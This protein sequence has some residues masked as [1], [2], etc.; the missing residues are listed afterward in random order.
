[1]FLGIRYLADKKEAKERFLDV[2]AFVER[3][4][5]LG[6]E[7]VYVL[8]TSAGGTSAIRFTQMYPE[9]T[10]GLILYCSAYPRLEA[11]EKELTM[12]GPPFFVCN[13]LMM[14]LISPLFE[15]LMGMEQSTIKEIMSM[16]DK[17]HGIVFDGKIT[18]TVMYNHYQEYDIIHLE[19]P[20]LIIYAKDDKLS[21]VCI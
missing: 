21:G 9:R 1:M 2:M 8:A 18:N 5:S 15:P 4:D 10:K 3:L 12:A 19:M 13:N 17:K 20:V 11:L 14:W 16:E 6:L 7:Q